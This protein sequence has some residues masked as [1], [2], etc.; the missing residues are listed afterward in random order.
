MSLNAWLGLLIVLV[1]LVLVVSIA[2]AV[3][4]YLWV[5]DDGG[6]EHTARDR[7]RNARGLDKQRFPRQSSA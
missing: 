2:G 7:G 5:M 1:P 6:S 3:R 4:I